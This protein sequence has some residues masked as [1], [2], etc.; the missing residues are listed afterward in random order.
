[1]VIDYDKLY[2]DESKIYDLY[3]KIKN[4]PKTET[5]KDL[6]NNDLI[7]DGFVDTE[8][9]LILAIE[10]K[11]GSPKILKIITNYEK[12]LFEKLNLNDC[13]NIIHASIINLGNKNIL[14]MDYYCG[15]LEKF[16]QFPFNILENNF[17][18]IKKALNYI[19]SKDIVHMDVKPDNIFIDFN[20]NWF[21][22]DF[23]ASKKIGENINFTT[24]LYYPIPLMNKK[25]N[26]KF[27]LFMLGI[28]MFFELF[29]SLSKNS[30]LITINSKVSQIKILNFLN[31]EKNYQNDENF[32][33]YQNDENFK[34]LKNE[35][36]DLLTNNYIIPEDYIN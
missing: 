28:T 3:D 16:P 36:I 1:M 21:L 9:K 11:T 15:S 12:N 33:N 5:R 29:K 25:A 17:K 2:K 10:K 6:M 22:G 26:P 4:L 8:Y 32:K 27:D 14:K 23:G 35:I 19:H 24:L 30:P 18:K 34:N 13:E 31:D 7:A 20:G